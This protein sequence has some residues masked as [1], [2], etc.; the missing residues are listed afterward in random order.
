MAKARTPAQNGDVNWPEVLKKYRFSKNMKQASLAEDLNVTQ[1]MISRWE[2]GAIAPG[3]DMQGRILAMV[4]QETLATPMVGWRQFVTDQPAIAAVIDPD[5]RIETVSVGLI[6]ETGIGRADM[7]GQR[8]DGVFSGDLLKLFSW[9]STIGF[10]DERVETVESADRY[11][12][13]RPDGAEDSFCVHNMH[14]W[15]RGED[16]RPR[17]I[18]TGAR[19]DEAE[20]EALREEF[21]AQARIMPVD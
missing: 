14:W 21:G 20:F 1:A 7:E 19:V 16:R 2:S 5:G 9:L 8:I 10:F 13:H 18:L 6:R 4:E 11:C 12:I 17:W 15:R 3:R